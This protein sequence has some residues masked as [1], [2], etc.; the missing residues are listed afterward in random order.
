ML[1]R[2]L[3]GGLV[4][5]AITSVMILGVSTPAQA[6]TTPAASAVVNLATALPHCNN[7]NH[8]AVKVAPRLTY[9]YFPVVLPTVNYNCI[10]ERGNN[11]PGV[12]VLQSIL[13]KCHGQRL[14]IDSIFGTATYNALLA[15]QRQIGVTIDGI[16][17]PQTRGKMRIWN[18]FSGCQLASAYQGF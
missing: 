14:Q 18:D 13:N 6:A 9:G 15:V 1:S 10:L 3:W 2:K 8:V 7:L 5:V 11:N 16:Y 12:G 17:G 4:A